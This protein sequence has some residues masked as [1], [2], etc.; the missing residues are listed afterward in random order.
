MGLACSNDIVNKLGGDIKIQKS[1]NGFTSFVFKLPVLGQ[2]SKDIK[3]YHNAD[4]LAQFKKEQMVLRHTDLC[5][6]FKSFQIDSF[7]KLKQN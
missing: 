2:T 4:L 6:H 7:Y 5:N 3:T 1:I